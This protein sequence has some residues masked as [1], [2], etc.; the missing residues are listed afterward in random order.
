MGDRAGVGGASQNPHAATSSAVRTA[1][2]GAW[3]DGVTA[4]V[5]T[6]MRTVGIRPLLLK[7]PSIAT[8]LYGDGAPRP[9]DDSDLLVA[10]GSYRQA[11][12]VLRELG[13]HHLEYAWLPYVQTWVR[14]SDVSGDEGGHPSMVD[15][16]RSLNG[17]GAPAD[18]VW[19]VL[20]AHA[21]TLQIGGID[22][23]VLRV[24]ARALHVALHAAQHG[25]GAEQP[26][27]DLT[28]AMRVADQHVWREGADLARRLNAVPAFA[29]GLRL[30]PEGARLA[31]RLRLPAKRPRGVALRVGPQNPVA[32]AL[33]SLASE[34]SFRARGQLLLQALAPS[35]LYMR[36]WSATHMARWPVALRE[37]SLGLWLAY[38]W[39]PLWNLGRLPKAITALRRVRQDQL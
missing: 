6:A 35:R 2:L 30:D 39:R 12:E 34:R 27:D 14:R 32:I 17:V 3:V 19:G 37:G 24:P 15:L 16:H 20:S 22:V 10:P 33:E 13:F 9:Y 23:E 26:L 36:N 11:G 8:W 18:I 38:L 21:D 1:A 7:G 4:E 31:Q 25:A 28:R 5:V 29:A